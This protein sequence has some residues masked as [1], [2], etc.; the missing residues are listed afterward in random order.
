MI[1]HQD[2]MVSIMNS[3]KS[4]GSSQLKTFMTS[5]TIFIKEISALEASTPPT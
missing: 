4:V 5:V 1:N 3:L 2:Q